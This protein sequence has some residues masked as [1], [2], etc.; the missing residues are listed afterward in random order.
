MALRRVSSV[1]RPSSTSKAIKL[2]TSGRRQM[3]SNIPL[4]APSSEGNVLAVA[5]YSGRDGGGS[6][7]IFNVARPRA[8]TVSLWDGCAGDLTTLRTRE[9]KGSKLRQ[10]LKLPRGN[11]ERGGVR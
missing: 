1:I 10:N 7:I 4:N 8:R 6:I 3:L 9:R 5:I 11:R 2:P